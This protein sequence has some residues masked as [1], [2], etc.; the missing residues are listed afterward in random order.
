[1]RFRLGLIT[2]VMGG[3]RLNPKQ[4][5]HLVEL[6]RD[7]EHTLG[8]LGELEALFPVTGSTIYRAVARADAHVVA[9]ERQPE[10]GPFP[11]S[12]PEL[13]KIDCHSGPTG[14][15]HRSHDHENTQNRSAAKPTTT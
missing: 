1:M 7:G 8:D 13:I 9:H 11:P 5:A 3:M 6:Y 12:D 4:K 15:L 10:T 14:Q 2:G